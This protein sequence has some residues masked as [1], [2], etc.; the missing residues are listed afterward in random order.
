MAIET[1]RN[2]YYSLYGWHEICLVARKQMLKN[3]DLSK[4][5]LLRKTIFSSVQH[6]SPP[7]SCRSNSEQNLLNLQNLSVWSLMPSLRHFISFSVHLDRSCIRSKDLKGR[8]IFSLLL[9]TKPSLPWPYWIEQGIW[10]ESRCYGKQSH[11]KQSKQEWTFR[12]H[13]AHLPI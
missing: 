2:A 1:R 7:Q 6:S 8:T 12:G 10:W 13:F 4:H 3:W 11:Q 5:K 9:D